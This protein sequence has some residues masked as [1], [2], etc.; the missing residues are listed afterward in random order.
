MN[1]ATT[2]KQLRSITGMGPIALAFANLRSYPTGAETRLLDGRILH[3]S[4][5]Y[6]HFPEVPKK[7]RRK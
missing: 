5:T 2:L 3:L 6:V 4:K 7:A 1:N